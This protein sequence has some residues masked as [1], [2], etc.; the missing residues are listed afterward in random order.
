M[1][2]LSKDKFA[3]ADCLNVHGEFSAD[4]ISSDKLPDGMTMDRGSLQAIFRGCF[5]LQNAGVSFNEGAELSMRIH[6]KTKDGTGFDT[7]A[8]QKKDAMWTAVGK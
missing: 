6:M 1:T 2:L 8:E 7:I 5:P 4:G 3:G